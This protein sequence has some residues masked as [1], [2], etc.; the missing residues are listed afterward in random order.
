MPGVPI[1]GNERATLLAGATLN[2]RGK[3]YYASG[4]FKGNFRLERETLNFSSGSAIRC[5][6]PE[7]SKPVT[8]RSSFIGFQRQ[9]NPRATLGGRVGAEF[10]D[11]NGPSRYSVITPE[12][13][14]SLLLSETLSL[15]GS[16]GVSFASVN[17]GINS[18][19]ST[20]FAGDVSLCSTTVRGHLC[21]HGSISQ[22][23]AT[24]AGPAKS[25]SIGLDYVRQL[26]ANQSIQFSVDA[27][28]YKSPTAFVV[29]TSFSCDLFR[30]RG[31]FAQVW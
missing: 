3:S 5:S 20:G 21:A 25:I 4:H 7:M 19:N 30:G 23:A 11:Y 27:N 8:R 28:R 16:A 1:L 14:G 15:N 6:K 9:I 31:L 17:D 18:N 13:T 2:V 24:S 26:D 22:T 29:G 10:T 12:V